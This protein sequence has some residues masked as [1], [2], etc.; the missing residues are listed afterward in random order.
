MASGKID[1]ALTDEMI[2]VRHLTKHF[3]PILAVDDVSLAVNP[4]APTR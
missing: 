4:R 2:S 3:G 1:A